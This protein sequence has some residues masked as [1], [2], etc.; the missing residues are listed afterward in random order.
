MIIKNQFYKTILKCALIAVSI[1]GMG[2]SQEVLLSLTRTT[3]GGSWTNVGYLTDKNLTTAATSGTHPN[4]IEYSLGSTQVITRAKLNEDNAGA[5]KI[6]NWKIQYW[7]GTA[8]AD[9]FAYTDTPN[10]NND[11]WNSV[12]F[13]NRE[14]DR[15]RV[16]LD[17]AGTLEAFELEVYGQ[18]LAPG[19]A[20]SGTI[21]PASAG[22]ISGLGWRPAGVTTSIQAIP[23]AG[24]AFSNW[25]G[26]ISS[27]SN[28]TSLIMNKNYNVVANFVPTNPV[29][30]Y[31]INS[32]PYIITRP[33]YYYLNKNLTSSSTTQDAIQISASNV[34]I[35][36][37]GFAITG[38]NKTSP[39]AGIVNA[40]AVHNIKIQNGTIQNFYIGIVIGSEQGS[41]GAKLSSVNVINTNKGIE[42][43]GVGNFA[44][45]CV[46][47]NAEGAE[48]LNG[49]FI[50]NRIDGFGV[51]GALFVNKSSLF[52]SYV[53]TTSDIGIRVN[54]GLCKNNY[55]SGGQYGYNL[56]SSLFTKNVANK[57]S[58]AN[59]IDA[60][61]PNGQQPSVILN[62]NY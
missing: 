51:N 12:S 7:T 43:L 49:I 34:T 2:Y 45:N 25:S 55:S 9:A 17:N 6:G 1:M 13:T 60:S 20:V 57:N 22:S 28:P 8:W 42:L 62:D 36:L 52:N 29:G 27:T 18:T 23:S 4:W 46:V 39:Y 14:T 35:D 41:T 40:N 30:G 5:W 10:L 47:S 16:Y 61:L 32:L 37:K 3:D 15:I 11:R 50:N 53:S 31:L 33:G 38:P 19:F 59:Y 54:A 26:D 48:L 58:V 21:S 24:Y 44:E 56:I